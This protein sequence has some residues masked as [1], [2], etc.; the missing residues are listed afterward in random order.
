MSNEAQNE[1]WNGPAG[2]VWVQAQEYMDQML[3]P[4]SR[5]AVEK[6]ALLDRERAIDVGCGCGGTSYALADSGGAVWGLDISGPMVA[7]AKESSDGGKNVAFSVGDAAVQAYTT[8]HNLIFSR[9]GVMF[10]DDPIAAFSNLRSALVPGGRLVFVCWQVP[11]ENL[12]MSV[13]GRAVQPFL[14][15]AEAQN[16]RAPGPFA[17]ADPNWIEEILADAGYSNI[18]IESVTP[19]LKVGS[20]VEEAMDFQGRIGPLARV[21]AELDEDT[22]VRANEAVHAALSDYLTDDGVVLRSAAW[23]VSATNRD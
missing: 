7:R 16:P 14:P 9:F 11:K 6:A 5:R 21:L 3:E 2:D 8:D 10:F 15:P 17:F 19:D 20:T 13:A 22:Q 4:L 1:F 23:L 18:E 12:W